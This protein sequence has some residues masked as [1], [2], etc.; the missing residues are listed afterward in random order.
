M[1]AL[2]LFCKAGGTGMVPPCAVLPLGEVWES[3]SL[4]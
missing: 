3:T 2:D 1:K 4:E